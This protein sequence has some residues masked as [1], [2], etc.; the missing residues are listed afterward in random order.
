MD[1]QCK[2]AFHVTHLYWYRIPQFFGLLTSI[3]GMPPIVYLIFKKIVPHLFHANLKVLLIVFYSTTFAFQ[4]FNCYIYSY[5]VIVPFLA[6]TE[7]DLLISIDSWRILSYPNFLTFSAPVSITVAI[8]VERLIAYRC[9]MNYE[10]RPTFNAY[11]LLLICVSLPTLS[12]RFLTN[13]LL[14]S[15]KFTIGISFLHNLFFGVYLSNSLILRVFLKRYINDEMVILALRGIFVTMPIYNMIAGIFGT[16]LLNRLRIRK[17]RKLQK[18][19]ALPYSG[20]IGA[21]N[22]HQAIQNYWESVAQ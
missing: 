8:T 6:K 18:V 15:S 19:V 9:R 20:P 12:S 7:C 10:H 2:N 11:I 1:Q 17:S 16:M 3:L 13:E 14:I 5:H 22:H 21:H 4:L